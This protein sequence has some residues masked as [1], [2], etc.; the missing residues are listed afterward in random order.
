MY[1]ISTAYLNGESSLGTNSLR[2]C[3]PSKMGKD[4]G[5]WISRVSVL[6][7]SGPIPSKNHSNAL[8]ISFSV[9]SWVTILGNLGAQEKKD[10]LC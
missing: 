10:N 3:N 5:S 4:G 8:S 1:L 2:L 6:S 9:L 7:Q